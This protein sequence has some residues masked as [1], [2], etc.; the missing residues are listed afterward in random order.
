MHQDPDVSV[1]DWEASLAGIQ[2]SYDARWE[3]VVAEAEACAG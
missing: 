1:E 3:A 2:E